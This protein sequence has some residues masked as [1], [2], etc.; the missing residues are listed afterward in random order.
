MKHYQARRS[1]DGALPPLGGS[2]ALREASEA[3]LRVLLS[4]LSGTPDD[5]AALAA[6]AD[7]SPARAAAA[8]HYWLAAGVLEEGDAA[9]AASSVPAPAEPAGVSH[10]SAGVS[11][12][13]ADVSHIPAEQ[14]AE[15]GAGIP[16]TLPAK[17]PLRP[18]ATGLSE[19][20]AEE[21]AA[22]IRENP[23]RRAFIETC[24]QTVGR[25]FNQK[26]LGILTSLLD[27]Y[28]FSPAYLLTLISYCKKKTKKFS[29]LYLEKTAASMLERE[30][31]SEEQLAAYLAAEER[32][33]REEWQL[34]R[35]LGIGERPLSSGERTYLHRWAGEFGYGADVIGIAYDIAVNYTGKVSL[36]YMN[37]L[38]TGWHGAG[39]HTPAEVDARLAREREEHLAAAQGGAAAAARPRPGAGGKTAPVFSTTVGEHDRSATHGSSF[40]GEDYMSAALR[41]SYGDSGDE[42]E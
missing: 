18:V 17:P 41:R 31:L 23:D 22:R 40:S 7:C 30:C 13:P 11:G 20:S 9:P 32:F 16:V 24:E 25:I 39:C 37:K 4:L 14:P 5:V 15:A 3:E 12:T 26:E 1:P 35:L 8:L 34:R 2:D 19:R 29:F 28:P 36:Q 21:I 42:E 33:S 27:D 6:A 10:P 38:L